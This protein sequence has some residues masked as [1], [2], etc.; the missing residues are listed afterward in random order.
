M[1]KHHKIIHAVL[2]KHHPQ[3]VHKARKLFRF[4]Y[5]K[6]VFLVLITILSYF[7]FK[8]PVIQ[9]L[10]LS[11]NKLNYLGFLIAGVLFA[12]GFS[13]PISIGFFII[14]QPSNLFLATILGGFG[15]VIGD[16][17]IFKTIKS[18]FKD[19][20]EELK[21][22][23][24]IKKIEEIVKKNKHVLIRHYLLYIFVGI[25][26]ASPV[27]DEIGVSILAGLTTIKESTLALIGFILQS[28]VIFLILNFSILI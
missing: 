1:W 23:K 5:P 24:I 7:I 12:F 15:A 22:K 4:K 20:F 11:L 17:I 9:G 25:M 3:A 27:S 13:A 6:L 16:I 28:M 10:I 14:S 18:S 21:K 19:E 2:R 8:Q 26:I